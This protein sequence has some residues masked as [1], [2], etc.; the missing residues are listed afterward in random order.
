MKGSAPPKIS[1]L[2][3]STLVFRTATC[4]AVSPF[5]NN[6]NHLLSLYL[7]VSCNVTAKCNISVCYILSLV[8][9]GNISFGVASFITTIYKDSRK[10]KESLPIR[11]LCN[12]SCVNE[13]IQTTTKMENVRFHH[14]YIPYTFV[15]LMI[16]SRSL[17]VCCVK[18]SPDVILCG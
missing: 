5:W 9:I 8:D 16:N 3:I 18:S 15:T 17:T 10:K 4:N 7:K 12:S 14:S 2:T 6:N 11:Y 13:T 1:H